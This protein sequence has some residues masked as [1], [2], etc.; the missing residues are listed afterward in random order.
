TTASSPAT[1]RASPPKPKYPIATPAPPPP[2]PPPPEPNASAAFSGSSPAQT[3][4]TAA[5]AR[6]EDHQSPPSGDASTSAAIAAAAASA[7]PEECTPRMDME[8]ETELQ[9][10]DL[11]RL[12][13]FKL[14]FNVRRRY[15]NRSKTSGEV[16]SC[17]FACSRE[18]FKD[19]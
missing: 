1:H 10:Y 5:S 3:T 12:Y 19:H 17:K 9:A 2:P 15:T 6:P 8:F 18:G 11:Y 4:S 13:A 7:R 16:T 14:G